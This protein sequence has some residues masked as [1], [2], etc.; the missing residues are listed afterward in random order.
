MNEIKDAGSDSSKVKAAL[1]QA[2]DVAISEDEHVTKFG[3]NWKADESAGQD[4]EQ[5]VK[6]GRLPAADMAALNKLGTIKTQ[7]DADVEAFE[8][9]WDGLRQEAVGVNQRAEN[10]K[11][12]QDQLL[13]DVMSL[14]KQNQDGGKRFLAAMKD[15]QAKEQA[16]Q[17]EIS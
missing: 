13:Q 8:K 3:A 14:E 7:A 15:L 16:W 11:I 17:R 6:S 12:N 5:K 2:K 1:P 4:L 10:G 9:G